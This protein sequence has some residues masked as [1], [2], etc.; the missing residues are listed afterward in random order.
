MED[1]DEAFVIFVISLHVP[2]GLSLLP[3]S[4]L[5]QQDMV[6]FSF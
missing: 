5:L 4:R 1:E 3:L 6:I 2:G